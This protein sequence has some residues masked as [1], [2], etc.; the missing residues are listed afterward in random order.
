M[1]TQEIQK[2]ALASIGGPKDSQA[3]TGTHNFASA[4]VREMVLYGISQFQYAFSS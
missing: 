2:A 1:H 4:I 3:D